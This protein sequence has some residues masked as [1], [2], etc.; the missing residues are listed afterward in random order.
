MSRSTARHAHVYRGLLHNHA[1]LAYGEVGAWLDGRARAAR[2]TSCRRFASSS[3]CRTRR[4]NACD[5]AQSR[6]GTQL[7]HVEASPVVVDGK[8]IDLAVATSQ[9]GARPDRGL[10]GRRNRAS[11]LPPRARRRPCGG[12]CASPSAG[13][14]S[15]RSRPKWGTLPGADSGARA[16][17]A[18]RRAA[19]PEHF[20]DLSLSVVKLLGP[21]VYVLERRS[22]TPP[23]RP[24]RARGRGYVHSTAP[25]RRFADLVTQRLLYALEEKARSRTRRRAHRHRALHG[26]GRR[27]AQGRTDDEKIAG[28]SMLAERIGESFLAVVTAASPKG[29]YARAVEPTGRRTGG[30]RRTWPGCRRHRA[31]E[32][33][34]R[35]CRRGYIDFEHD[36]TGEARKLARSRNKKAAADRLRPRLARI[37]TPR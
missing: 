15:S 26:T 36:A 3:A 31:V 2:I 29:T 21:G 18:Q 7:R 23:G 24:L 25:N 12:S 10:H 17:L 30:A 20:A 16:F 35:R 34:R 4:R 11:R 14:G 27:G 13:I 28:A 19:D 22:A 32:A 37:S 6:R 8:V 33:R 1:K 9:S 5:C